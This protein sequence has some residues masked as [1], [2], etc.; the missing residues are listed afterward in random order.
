MFDGEPSTQLHEHYD[1][2]GTLTGTTVVTVP[3]WTDEDR[4]WALG[5]QLRDDHLCPRGH[6]LTDST[7]ERWRWVPQAPVVCHACVAVE[8]E[9]KRR[10]KDPDHRSMLFPVKKVPQRQPRPKRGR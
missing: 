1:P 9:A 3:G 10:A 6:D 7:D 2:A 4:A 8:Q 5:L